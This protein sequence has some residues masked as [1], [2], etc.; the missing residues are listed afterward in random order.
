M[1]IIFVCG[2]RGYY[3]R[4]CSGHGTVIINSGQPIK[5]AVPNSAPIAHFRKH[6]KDPPWH[7]GH[8]GTYIVQFGPVPTKVSFTMVQLY[9]EV[10]IANK[11]FVVTVAKSARSCPLCPLWHFLFPECLQ[12]LD[13]W[14]Q[15]D[16]ANVFRRCTVTAAVTRVIFYISN[17]EYTASLLT[18][19]IVEIFLF[20]HFVN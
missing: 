1:A 14:T 19:S 13:F 4:S 20:W 2:Y 3:T 10:A 18:Q 8:N 17:D 9:N 12:N 16:T 6:F 15:L 11:S 7:N 5:F